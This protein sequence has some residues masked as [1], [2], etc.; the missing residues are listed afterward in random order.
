LQHNTINTISYPAI[1]ISTFAKDDKFD[2]TNW[3]SWKQIIKVVAILR[4]VYR[5]LDRSIKQLLLPS[6]MTKSLAETL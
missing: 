5:Y 4:E 3:S 6:A 1:P 2:G